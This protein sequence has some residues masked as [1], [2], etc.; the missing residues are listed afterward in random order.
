MV[1]CLRDGAVSWQ[2]AGHCWEGLEWTG[3]SEP[4]WHQSPWLAA[5]G[6]RVGMSWSTELSVGVQLAAVI[7][8]ALCFCVW[9]GVVRDQSW[10]VG[11]R[12]VLGVLLQQSQ[13]WSPS[14]N[15]SFLEWGPLLAHLSA[16]LRCQAAAFHAVHARS[17][18]RGPCSPFTSVTALHYPRWH[19]DR[20]HWCWGGQKAG[21]PHGV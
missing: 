10:A 7:A 13:S 16:S 19:P 5:G 17:G 3:S 11:S 4:C 14:C 20:N 2:P 18:Q 1:A 15:P 9:D 21:Q 6:G 12:G 8:P